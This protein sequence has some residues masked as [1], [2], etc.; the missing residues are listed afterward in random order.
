MKENKFVTH[1]ELGVE[2]RL[3]S[4]EGSYR[5]YQRYFTAISV[6]I[7]A[8]MIGI[9]SLLFAL[10]NEISEVKAEVSGLK[11]AISEVKEDVGDLKHD[12]S[13]LKIDVLE[14]KFGV[15]NLDGRVS[16][17]ETY[18]RIN[19]TATPSVSNDSSSSTDKDS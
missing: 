4:L 3:S 17:V 9:F 6:M 12:V 7:L 18:L 13:E 1:E 19:G 11:V 10:M 16:N 15:A 5:R 14:L 2:R 8:T